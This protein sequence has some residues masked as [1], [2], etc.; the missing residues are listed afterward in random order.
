M[1]ATDGSGVERSYLASEASFSFLRDLE[2]RNLVVPVVGDF[3]GPRAIR[4]VGAYLKARGGT[5]SA[6]YL[7]N[8]EQYL[9]QDG[10]WETFC[11]SV[12]SLPLDEH[13]TFIRSQNG[14]GGFA[15]GGFVSSLGR[16]AEEVRHCGP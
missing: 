10:K 14:G 8:V 3:G 1:T 5:V 11:R 13:S 9:R 16:M 7:S 15:R 2:A 4:A 12:A 6:F